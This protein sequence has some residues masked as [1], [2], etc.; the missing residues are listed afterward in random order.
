MSS[1]RTIACAA[2]AGFMLS[3]CR[4]TAE[5]GPPVPPEKKLLIWASSALGPDN[6]R[7]HIAELGKENPG[8]DGLIIF[9]WPNDWTYRHWGGNH[10]QFGARRY[11]MAD[12]SRTIEAL[13][14][15][16]MGHITENFLLVKTTIQAGP[17]GPPTKEETVNIDW[18]DE[19]WPVI[20]ENVG[21][22][23]AVAKEVGFKGLVLDFEEYQARHNPLHKYFRFKE[24]K[25]YRVKNGLPAKS[26]EEYTV[27]VRKCGRRMMQAVTK[28]YPDSTILMIPDTGWPGHAHYD[29]LPAFVDGILE[30]AGPDIRL[31]DGIEQG[32]PKQTYA[33]FMELRRT[34]QREGPRLSRVPELYSKRLTYGLGLWVDYKPDRF[35]GWHTAESE[36]DTNFRS[37]K[38]LE[39]ALYNAF[40]AS[41][42]Y[43][44][45][46]QR[47]PDYWLQ[48]SSRS[49]PQS[50]L[51]HPYQCIRCPHSVMPQGY[52]DALVDC[53]RPH[54]LDWTSTVSTEPRAWVYTAEQL[55]AMGP[56]LISNAGFETWSKGPPDP[57]DDWSVS[58]RGPF[59]LCQVTDGVKFG[60]Y[61]LQ[62]SKPGETGLVV[63]QGLA[64]APYRGKTIVM[65]A[66]CKLTADSSCRAQINSKVG[67]RWV[68]SSSKAP[69][70][71]GEWH[72]ICVGQTIPDKAV[73]IYLQLFPYSHKPDAPVQFDNAIAVVLGGQ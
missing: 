21:L 22:Y 19:R 30:G 71:D 43:V 44:W 73:K 18:F 1:K 25:E 41:D 3:V 64:A 60:E 24:F 70:Q 38:R 35:G 5:M 57:P 11:T 56:N 33:E 47:H 29:L 59:D 34:A 14:S 28:A 52:L 31:I 17:G 48:P 69:P 8:L 37:P 50:K 62:F 51:M 55:A 46:Y 45:L 10:G 40:T 2:A 23:A 16:D 15:T 65:G 32:Y 58:F 72:F 7:Q 66:W 26:F 53:R 27:K 63:D 6:L 13:K 49:K 68:G 54:D 4:V 9:F 20:A 61:A 42:K 36:L 12:F 39:H 67:P